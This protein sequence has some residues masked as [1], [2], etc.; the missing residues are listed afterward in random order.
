ML[1]AR[2]QLLLEQFVVWQYNATQFGMTL[3]QLKVPRPMI[4]RERSHPKGV[5]KKRKRERASH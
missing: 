3:H 4:D 5:A 2:N 1:I